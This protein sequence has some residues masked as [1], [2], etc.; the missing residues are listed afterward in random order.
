MINNVKI[1]MMIVMNLKS[2][3]KINHSLEIKILSNKIQLHAFKNSWF[4]KNSVV[5]SSN[6]Q[7]K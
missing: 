6:K 5:L 3:I 2:L 7:K 1:M 4:Q